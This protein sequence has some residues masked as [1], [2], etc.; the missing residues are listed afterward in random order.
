[1]PLAPSP[2][3]A[4]RGSDR[5]SPAHL[6]TRPETRGPDLAARA[7]ESSLADFPAHTHLGDAGDPIALASLLWLNTLPLLTQIAQERVTSSVFCHSPLSAGAFVSCFPR[8]IWEGKACSPIG[9]CPGPTPPGP[10]VACCPWPA[11][12]GPPSL[13]GSAPSPPHCACPAQPLGRPEL[14]THSWAF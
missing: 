9:P 12:P 6:P 5:G 13:S 14:L 11:V 7:G 8:G 1:M 3:W 10:R 2:S 4:P